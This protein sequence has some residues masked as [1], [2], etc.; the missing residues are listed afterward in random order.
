MAMA[1][2][3]VV[4]AVKSRFWELNVPLRNVPGGFDSGRSFGGID[5]PPVRRSIEPFVG[6][7]YENPTWFGWEVLACAYAS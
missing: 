4:L 1:H 3:S 7:S 2:I 5:T 6:V